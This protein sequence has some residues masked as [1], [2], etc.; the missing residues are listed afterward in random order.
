M[1]IEDIT[2]FL[3]HKPIISTFNGLNIHGH[4]HEKVMA[5]PYYINVSMERTN[6]HPLKLLEIVKEW[7]NKAV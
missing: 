5:N 4:M 6:Y 7:K 1:E 3:S 2:V